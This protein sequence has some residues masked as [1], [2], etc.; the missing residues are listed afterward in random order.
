MCWWGLR[1]MSLVCITCGT[2]ITKS[3][4]SDRC[5]IC[6]QQKKPY[7]RL[8][9]RLLGTAKRKGQLVDLTYDEFVL[10]TGFK[11]CHYCN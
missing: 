6:S 1:Y 3:S 8:Y 5:R 4:S 9:T 2:A 10:M 11:H 7:H